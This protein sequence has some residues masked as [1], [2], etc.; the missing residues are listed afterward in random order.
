MANAIRQFKIQNSKL[1]I[2]CVALLVALV[3]GLAPPLVS[4]AVIVGGAVGLLLLRYPVWGAYLLVLSVPVQKAVSYNAG[5]LEIT[6]T[7]ALFVVVLGIWWAWL[8]VRQDRRLVLTPIAVMLIFYF[9]SMLASL[10]VT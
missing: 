3:A 2:A 10:W 8:T 9:V 5:P 1:I 6:V 7:Q 4:A